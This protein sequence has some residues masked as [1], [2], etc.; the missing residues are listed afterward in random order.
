MKVQINYKSVRILVVLGIMMLAIVLNLKVFSNGKL[1][2]DI[3]FKKDIHMMAEQD[4]YTNILNISGCTYIDGNVYGNVASIN[5]DIYVNGNVSGN[6][7]CL[8]G[9]IH[10]G[11]NGKILGKTMKVKKSNKGFIAK[12]YEVGFQNILYI[13]FGTIVCI[14]MYIIDSKERI[15]VANNLQSRLKEKFVHGY[16]IEVSSLLLSVTL[17]LYLLGL[18]FAPAIGML[19]IVVLITFTT[20]IIGFVSLLIYFGKKINSFLGINVPYPVFIFLGVVIYEFIRIIPYIGFIISI[21]IVIPLSLG[22]IYVEY[23][24]GVLKRLEEGEGNVSEIK[25]S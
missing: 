5:G 15:K 4:F 18:Q 3:K 8:L 17:L 19:P 22:S 23:F 11:K 10:Y 7:I 14:C 21:F 2:N 6:V 16:I 1:A 25:N 12:K 24:K 9:K 13:V 20:Y